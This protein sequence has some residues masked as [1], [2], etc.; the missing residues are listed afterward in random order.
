MAEQTGTLWEHDTTQASCCHGFASPVER[1]MYRDVLG[2]R[3]V[4]AVNKRV[5]LGFADVPLE[6][7]SGTMPVGDGAVTVSWK[8]EG[9][10]FRYSWQ[11]PKRF[12]V[13]VDTSR[14]PGAAV[15]E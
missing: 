4:D 3:S 11:A 9:G 14:L 10:A 7:C 12:E 1:L 6:R 13:T 8:K 15:R 2:I 5:A